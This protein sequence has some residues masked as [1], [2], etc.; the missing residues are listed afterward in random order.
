[1]NK[2]ELNKKLQGLNMLLGKA[3]KKLATAKT[4]KEKADAQKAI[5][6]IKGQITEAKKALQKADENVPANSKKAAKAKAEL[7]MMDKYKVSEL[8]LN[9]KGAYFTNQN[10][11][12]LSEK[13]KTKVKKLTREIVESQAK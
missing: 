6:N 9:S 1:M 2:D 12:E 3:N 5:D 7:K 10:L 11:A 4:D 13:D 8:F